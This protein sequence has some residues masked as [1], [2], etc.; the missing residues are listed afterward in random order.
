MNKEL[1]LERSVG[2]GVGVAGSWMGAGSCCCSG[3]RVSV[4]VVGSVDWRVG[5]VFCEGC[6]FAIHE[7]ILERSDGWGVEISLA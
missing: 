3:A 4:A 7:V 6:G 5:A 1:I 2:G